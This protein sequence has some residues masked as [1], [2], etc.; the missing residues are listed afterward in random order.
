MERDNDEPYQILFR[1]KML[2]RK[3]KQSRVRHLDSSRLGETIPD[4][5]MCDALVA[6]YLRLFEGFLRIVHVPSFLA[7]YERFWADRGAASPAFVMQLQLCM[8]LGSALYDETFTLRARATQWLLE[9]HMWFILPPAKG[10]MTLTGLQNLCLLVLA[11]DV[12]AS[13]QLLTW[14]TTGDLVRKAMNMGLHR[15]PTQLGCMTRYTAEM[16]RRLWATILEL[17][18]QSMDAGGPPLLSGEDY[19]T[20]PPS[21]LDDEQLVDGDASSPGCPGEPLS[22]QP[23]GVP[24]KTSVLIALARSLPLRTAILKHV[25]GLQAFDSYEETLRLHGRM[26]QASRVLSAGLASLASKTRPGLPPAVT[27]SHVF[28]AEMCMFRSLHALH[29]PVVLRHFDDPQYYFSRKTQLDLAAQILHRL[30]LLERPWADAGAAAD[31]NRLCSNGSGMW[32]IMPMQ[33]A[34]NIVIELVR[35]S[36]EQ[37][38]SLGCAAPMGHAQLYQS[39]EL[40]REWNLQRI[41]SGETNAKGYVFF[42]ACL[43]HINALRQGKSLAGIEAS[44]YDATVSAAGEALGAMERLAQREGVAMDDDAPNSPAFD[45][46]STTDLISWMGDLAWGG[47]SP[48]GSWSR[49]RDGL[50]DDGGVAMVAAGN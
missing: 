46:L 19:D 22:E 8:A 41:V 2:S 11:K 33:A 43:A 31:F 6:I 28:M 40:V 26:A 44:I 10:R 39:A 27:S 9:A 3:I 1:I 16:R 47:L 15:D 17:N 13:S 24:T 48:Q 25:N 20:L 50:A 29:Q 4:R 45:A 30:G 21:N 18:L 36:E 12:C 34:V 23:I 5:P 14:A 37:T 35:H 42:A 32:R 7:E 38:D 49:W